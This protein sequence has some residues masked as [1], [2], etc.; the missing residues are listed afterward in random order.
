MC[1]HLRLANGKYD[2]V[3]EY[4]NPLLSVRYWQK[5][6]KCFNPQGRDSW[7]PAKV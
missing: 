4:G 2:Q 6:E 7:L 1:N 5:S 3:H